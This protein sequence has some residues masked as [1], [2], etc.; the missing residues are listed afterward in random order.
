MLR[1]HVCGDQHG[2]FLAGNDRGRDDDVAFGDDLAQQLALAL[3]ERVVLCAGVAAG[4]LGVFGLD[5][6]LDEAPAQALDLFLRGRAQVVRRGDGAQPARGGD[7]LQ[8]GDA[9]ADHEDARRA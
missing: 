6:Q 8:A 7:R 5:G 1:D 4:V 2:R 9:G 3:V